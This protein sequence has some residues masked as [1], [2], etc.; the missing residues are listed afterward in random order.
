[1]TAVQPS[2]PDVTQICAGSVTP[3]SA[4]KR[5]TTVASVP[6]PRESPLDRCLVEHAVQWALDEMIADRETLDAIKRQINTNLSEYT[7]GRPVMSVGQVCGAHGRSTEW[8]L[9]WKPTRPRLVLE[10]ATALHEGG[11]RVG[12]PVIAADGNGKFKL[13]LKAAL[14]RLLETHGARLVTEGEI[15]DVGSASTMASLMSYGVALINYL[16]VLAREMAAVNY[17]ML[18]LE[19]VSSNAHFT[20]DSRG[21]GL[22][23]NE[24]SRVHLSKAIVLAQ[25]V[26]QREI[27]RVV[28]PK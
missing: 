16:Q 3:P 15:A 18:W 23:F 2:S 17:K 25:E 1:M 20:T 10:I 13:I 5:R 9:N 24:S 21:A 12:A 22:L 28:E 14:A 7:D 11:L 26:C 19:F 27:E 8:V 4:K 6:M